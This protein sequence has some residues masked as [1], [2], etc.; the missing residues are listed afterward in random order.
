MP[1]MSKEQKLEIKTRVLAIMARHVGSTRRIGMGEL[2]TEVFG[3]SWNNRINDTRKLR[4][5]LTELRKEGVPICSSAE[6]GGGY[7]LASAG[8][9]LEHYTSRLKTQAL[10]KLKLVATLNNCTL[11]ALLGQMQLA[12]HEGTDAEN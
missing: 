9:E 1:A 2:F 4:T 11:P 6:S 3:E 12:F 8:S 10:K 5:V 7:W